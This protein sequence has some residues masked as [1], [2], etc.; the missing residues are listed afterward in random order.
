MF[1]CSVVQCWEAIR[2]PIRFLGFMGCSLLAWLAYGSWYTQM[3]THLY[4]AF[5]FRVKFHIV[6]DLQ[7]PSR[8]YYLT[9]SGVRNQESEIRNQFFSLSFDTLTGHSISI[10]T[11]ILSIIDHFICHSSFHIVMIH[12]TWQ[13]H[14]TPYPIL[15]PMPP[16][17]ISNMFILNESNASNGPPYSSRASFVNP[18]SR[19]QT[20]LVHRPSNN[21]G[22]SSFQKKTS[23]NLCRSP[24]K[25]RDPR[26]CIGMSP[27]HG[28]GTPRP[29]NWLS[30]SPALG[31]NCQARYAAETR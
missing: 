13:V 11:T 22:P 3:A 14:H 21:P 24:E 30:Y 5:P 20:S 2:F 12:R 16:L 7:H 27:S 15:D 31:F 18:H 1:C 29:V 8:W 26:Q 25:Q 10:Q 23:F 28:L 17:P 4:F 6:G 9:E 19:H